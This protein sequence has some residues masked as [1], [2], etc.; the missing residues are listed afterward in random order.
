MAYLMYPSSAKLCVCSTLLMLLP[1]FRIKIDNG[2]HMALV[3]A[4]HGNLYDSQAQHLI[5]IGE[6]SSKISELI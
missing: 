6:R 5:S 1:K 2:S 3:K 4:T